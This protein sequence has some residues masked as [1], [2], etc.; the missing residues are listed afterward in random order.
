M[1]QQQQP[2]KLLIVD[3]DVTT[4]RLLCAAAEACGMESDMAIN[5]NHALLQLD[6]NKYDAVVTDIHMPQA[7]GHS[8]IVSLQEREERPMIFA[9]TA[10]DAPLI[11]KDLI[12]RGVDDIVF[13]PMNYELFAV[14]ISALLDR[15][16]ADRL[17]MVGAE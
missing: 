14:K 11:I 12:K 17:E 3:D 13:K 2:Y 7:N 10:I 8:L 4:R 9:A 16:Q 5:G 15:K 1:K 6:T